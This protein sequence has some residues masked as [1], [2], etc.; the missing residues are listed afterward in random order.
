[1]D[2]SLCK[3]TLVFPP[4]GEDAVVEFLLSAEPPISG[5]T[6]WVGDGHGLDFREASVNERVRGRVKLSVLV[7]VLPRQWVAKLLDDLGKNA[8]INSLTYWVEPVDIFGR[9]TAMTS[10]EVK[11]MEE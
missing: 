8:R 11:P 3:L 7:A 1:M 6:T 2:K 4:S 9:L 5:F 10:V